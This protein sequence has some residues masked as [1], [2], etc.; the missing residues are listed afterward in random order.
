MKKTVLIYLL[1]CSTVLTVKAQWG[2]FNPEVTILKTSD[3]H[4]YK[5][6]EFSHS[7]WLYRTTT[8]PVETVL[9]YKDG[10]S[11]PKTL[12]WDLPKMIEDPYS[13]DSFIENSFKEIFTAKEWDILV[14]E[15]IY[16]SIYISTDTGEVIG[17]RIR[18]TTFNDSIRSIPVDKFSRFEDKMKT[19]KFTLTPE[20]KNYSWTSFVWYA[21]R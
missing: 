21:D 15:K 8:W 6:V 19:L 16:L 10:T 9:T 4:Q 12:Y 5:W 2:T 20:G 17:L 11:L 1:L 18:F 3:G 13:K 7:V 14:D